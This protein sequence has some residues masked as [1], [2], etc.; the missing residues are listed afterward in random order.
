MLMFH[1]MQRLYHLFFKQLIPVF[2]QSI[3]ESFNSMTL[4]INLPYFFTKFTL[5]MA[6]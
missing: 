2:G 5:V 3:Y 1:L 4:D 6:G